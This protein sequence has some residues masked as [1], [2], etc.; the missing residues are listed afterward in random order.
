VATAGPIR[1]TL[2]RSGGFAGMAQRTVELDSADLPPELARE[3]EQRLAAA[4]FFEL[5]GTVGTTE[6]PDA[7]RYELTVDARGRR[8][9]VV[10]G[11]ASAP[12]PLLELIRFVTELAAG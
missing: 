8:H 4:S 1:I 2:T 3:L 12:E 10:A 6:T 9:T 11:D 5:P 7:F